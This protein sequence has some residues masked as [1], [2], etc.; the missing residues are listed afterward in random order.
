MQHAE[1]KELCIDWSH[2]L[3][4][5]QTKMGAMSHYSRINYKVLTIKALK[6]KLSSHIFNQ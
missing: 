2:V 3:E 6:E 1:E 5:C 4:V